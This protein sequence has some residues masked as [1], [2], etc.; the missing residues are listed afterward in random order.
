MFRQPA[1]AG[2]FYDADPATL[3]K[4][5]NS[6]ILK[7]ETKYKAMGVIVPHAGYVYSGETA[8]AVFSS[9]EIPSLI[10]ILGP[11]HTG[12]G[13]RISVMNKG[14]WRTPLGDVVINEPLAGQILRNCKKASKDSEAH[15]REHAIEVQLP[16]LQVLKKSFTF[17]PITLREHEADNLK[18]LAEA[19]AESITGKDVLLVASTDMTHYE[20]TEIAKEKDSYVLK[21]IEALDPEKML[22]EVEEKDISMCG[23]MPVYVAM[24]AAKILGAKEGKIVRYTNSGEKSGDFSSVVG[25]GG[26]VLY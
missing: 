6:Y 15:E 11:N 2:L 10:I 25:Y 8:G 13:P 16:F 9:V 4:R 23:W 14:E 18:A 26:A 7:T 22:K 5:V 3:K 21:A 24:H 1:V 20:S 12:M 19:I 17:V